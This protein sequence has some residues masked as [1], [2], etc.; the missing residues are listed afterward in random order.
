MFHRVL[1]DIVQSRQPGFLER[2]ASVPEFVHD[3]P[4]GSGINAIEPYRQFAMQMPHEITMRRRRVFEVHNNVIV[5]RKKGPRLQKERIVF[6][7]LEGC[8]AQK[9]QFCAGIEQPFPMQRCRG[10]QVSPVG[11]KV[12]R[13]RMRPTLAHIRV[14]SQGFPL[15]KA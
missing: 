4:A 1:M 12:M 10:N 9:I 15:T 14:L 13:R 3:P 8:V 5:I 11:R 7:Q 2:Q 6:C